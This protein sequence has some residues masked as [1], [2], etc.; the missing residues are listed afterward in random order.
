MGVFRQPPRILPRR[1]RTLS[2][3]QPGI[4]PAQLPALIPFANQGLHTIYAGSGYAVEQLASPPALPGDTIIVPTATTLYGWPILLNDDGTCQILAG[5]STA[6][7]SF[8]FYLYRRISGTI[9]GPG[10]VWL[11]D[12]KPVWTGPISGNLQINAPATFDL[13][14]YASSPEGDVLTYTLAGGALP[15][16]VTLSASG[17]LTGTP[18]Q[19]GSFSITVSA[20]DYANQS[21]TSG[22]ITLA[23]APQVAYFSGVQMAQDAGS[24]GNL[25]TPSKPPNVTPIS[26]PVRSRSI[27]WAA[28]C[29]IAGRPAVEWYPS[30]Q[31][32]GGQIQRIFVEQT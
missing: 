4:Q 1:Y 17:V 19:I 10:K 14:A 7:D 11:N 8:P 29:Q 21:T 16:G 5:G 18:S 32:G 26:P 31:F 6:R 23:V 25:L 2:W 30:Y 28:A 15:T 22:A 24:F 12:I 13:S 3:R 20:T 9:D 27:S